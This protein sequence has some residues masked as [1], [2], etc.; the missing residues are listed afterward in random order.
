MANVAEFAIARVLQRRLVLQLDVPDSLVERKGI[1]FDTQEF[2]TWGFVYKP[3][4]FRSML[5][6]ENRWPRRKLQWLPLDIEWD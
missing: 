4:D 3:E 1:S 2:V 6:L 5:R